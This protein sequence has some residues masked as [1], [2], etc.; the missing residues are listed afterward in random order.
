MAFLYPPNRGSL[1][2]PSISRFFLPSACTRLFLWKPLRRHSVQITKPLSA[3]VTTGTTN[4]DNQHLHPSRTNPLLR[5]PRELVQFR[6]SRFVAQLNELRRRNLLSEDIEM[7]AP[8]RMTLALTAAGRVHEDKVVDH[9]VE[10]IDHPH[11]L[12]TVPFAHPDRHELTRA[13]IQRCVPVIR[14]AAL[15]NDTLDGY[16]DVLLL[17]SVDPFLTPSQRARAPLGSYS[18][19][20]VKLAA[21][22]S[23]DHILQASCYYTM[24]NSIL[25]SLNLSPSTHAYLWL[26]SPQSPPMQLRG[27]TLDYLYRHSVKHFSG[28]LKTFDASKTP[29]PDAPLEDLLPWRTYAEELLV[30]SDSLR[31]IA[32]IRLSHVSQLMSTTGIDTLKQFAETP[33]DHIDALVCNYKLPPAVRALHKQ[34]QLQLRSREHP[35]RSPAYEL[36]PHGPLQA[37]PAPSPNDVFFDMEGFPLAPDGGLEY[38]FGIYPA[39]GT[40]FYSWWAHNRLQEEAAFVSLIS[41]LDQLTVRSEGNSIPRVFHYGHYEVSA[42]RR[43]AARTVTDAGMLAANKLEAMLEA[44]MFFDV[45]KFVKSALIVGDSSYSIK[46]IEKIVGVT[47]EG[48][49]LAD[50]ESSVAMYYEWRRTAHDDI[51]DDGTPANEMSHDILHEIFSYNRQ[52]CESLKKVVFWLREKFPLDEGTG[53]S[54]VSSDET[55]GGFTSESEIEYLPGAC[56]RTLELRA[57]DSS[58]IAQSS[59]LS[60]M[61]LQ[62][63]NK[64]ISPLAAQNLAHILQFYVRESAPDRRLFRDRVDMASTPRFEELFYDDKCVVGVRLK[65]SMRPLPSNERVLYAYSFNPEQPLAVTEGESMAFVIPSRQPFPPMQ[66]R[67]G[68]LRANISAFVTVKSVN[69]NESS[70]DGRLVL[71]FG[72]KGIST[73]PTFGVLVSA[74]DLAICDGPLRQSVLRRAEEVLEGRRNT[75][76]STFLNRTKISEEP[77]DEVWVKRFGDGNLAYESILQFLATR[78]REGVFVI[79]GPPGTGKT[80]LSGQLIRDLILNHGKTVAV[81]SNSHAAIDNLLRS[82]IRAGLNHDIVWKVGT[83]ASGGDGIKYKANVRDLVVQRFGKY[84]SLDGKEN[85]DMALSGSDLTPENSPRSCVKKRMRR[86]H[87]A[88]VGAT[89]YQLCREENDRKF[90]FIFMDEASQVTMAHMVA[91]GAC[92]KYA[93]LVGDQRQLEMPIKGAHIGDVGQSCL[94]YIV[95][96]NVAIVEPDRGTF[97]GVSYRMNGNLCR[98]VSDAF[99]NGALSSNKTCTGNHVLM[100]QKGTNI[101]E[102]QRILEGVVF[103][104]SN[105]HN[106]PSGKKLQFD[107]EIDRVSNVIQAMVGST[108]EVGGVKRALREEDFVVVAPYNAQVRALRSALPEN[109]RVGTV[110]KFQGQE[111]AVAVISTCTSGIGDESTTDSFELSDFAMDT[112]VR[113][114]LTDSFVR[115]HSCDPAER[116]GIRFCLQAN[117]LNVAVSRAQCVAVVIGNPDACSRLPLNRLEDIE[118][119][120][121]FEQLVLAGQERPTVS[122]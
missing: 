31:L 92:A 9:L 87:A 6:R 45:Y 41:W 47:R 15:S 46:T 110:D 82:A 121:L 37:L 94:S 98:F 90:D 69:L 67:N 39:Q 23:A 76:V 73:I 21:L 72:S 115:N 71:S 2:F 70:R 51:N 11:P 19:C 1:F 96:E 50:A 64:L 12:Y 34:A 60:D 16:A 105:P 65:G 100:E 95:G 111:A 93:V 68:R 35:D 116:R 42:L 119:A 27:Q 107:C 84:E 18:V 17:A 22:Y 20:E 54:D 113:D 29:F 25:R 40:N 43:V 14:N 33:F 103:C 106:V 86:N 77:E 36:T 59:K 28:F 88:L 99:Y 63:P 24:L 118:L 85:D 62:S 114:R 108:F 91:V 79:Q 55:E 75:L 80:M 7:D 97:L 44:G 122:K 52:D 57:F 102:G 109:V 120:A 13:A 74:G 5:S 8:T 101:F 49:E 10:Q 89:C 30:S 66:E 3:S 61:L 112:P 58:A 83:R 81:S 56:G 38:L 48:D 117:R 26:G 53:I 104:Q 32:G 4:N 78:K